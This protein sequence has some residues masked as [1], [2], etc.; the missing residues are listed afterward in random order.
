MC[1]FISFVALY[2]IVLYLRKLNENVKKET[3]HLFSH[4]L[5]LEIIYVVPEAF[6]LFF[7]LFFRRPFL[8]TLSID[9]SWL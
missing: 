6:F 5:N 9:A 1:T 7:S 8:P 4:L 2:C 3:L